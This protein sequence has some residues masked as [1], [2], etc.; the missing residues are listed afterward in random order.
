ME[1]MSEREEQ[2]GYPPA[3]TMAFQIEG[4]RAPQPLG[5]PPSQASPTAQGASA[6]TSQGNMYGGA[7]PQAMFTG[8]QPAPPYYGNPRPATPSPM[9][10]PP[11]PAGQDPWFWYR[12]GMAAAHASQAAQTANA[13]P[14]HA[15]GPHHPKHDEHKYGQM[16]N[17]LGRFLSGEADMNDLINGFFSLDFQND[18]FWKGALVGAIATLLLTNENVQKGLTGTIGAMFGKS[19]SGSE[20]P[21]GTAGEAPETGK[22]EKA[23]SK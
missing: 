4:T 12:Q 17:T 7:N 23:P 6:G 22:K 15:D 20:K 13:A 9:A 18:Q 2:A 1:Q 16:M 21:Q 19:M 5:G 14:P 11:G 8:G 3:N 10:F